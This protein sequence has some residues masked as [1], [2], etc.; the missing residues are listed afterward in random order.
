MSDLVTRLRAA[1]WTGQN[2]LPDM[3]ADEIERL[4]ARVEALIA[5][6]SELKGHRHALNVYIDETEAS[7]TGSGDYLEKTLGDMAE[8]R[9]MVRR[10]IEPF[11]N[12]FSGCPWCGIQVGEFHKDSCQLREA[13]SLLSVEPVTHWRSAIP[14]EPGYYWWRQ[15][16]R[17]EPSQVS[18]TPG[19]ETM[20]VH[21]IGEITGLPQEAWQPD[22]QWMPMFVAPAQMPTPTEYGKR[23][24]ATEQEKSDE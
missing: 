3:A 22:W 11:E 1:G 14:L 17:I 21:F 2:S 5:E 4:Q 18:R 7:H 24:A 10:L 20:Y 9:I 6:V 13:R 15:G 12:G 23:R 8:A 19:S 16:E